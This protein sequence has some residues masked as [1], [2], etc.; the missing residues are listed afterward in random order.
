MKK[1]HEKA[2]RY[3]RSIK[4]LNGNVNNELLEMA[5][6]RALAEK[7]NSHISDTK[8]QSSGS[9]SRLEETVIKLNEQE[10]KVSKAVD[11]LM[12]R[13]EFI[14]SQIDGIEDDDCR[15][16]LRMYF[17]EDARFVDIQKHMSMSESAVFRCY[18][19]GL[20]EFEKKYWEFL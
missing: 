12:E 7:I 19:K 3:L 17:I 6:L 9:R 11:I 18:E 4:K 20:R 8:V 16:V 5:R 13:Q 1:S 15:K 2:K 10:K 14:M